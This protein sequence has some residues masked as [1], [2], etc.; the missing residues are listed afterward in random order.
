MRLFKISKIRS[1]YLAY[2]KRSYLKP[3]FHVLNPNEERK[4]GLICFVV[5]YKKKPKAKF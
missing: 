4:L 3:Y 2:N 5:I 1:L